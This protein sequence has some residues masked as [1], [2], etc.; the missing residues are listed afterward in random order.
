MRHLVETVHRRSETFEIFRRSRGGERRQRAAVEGAFE[1]DD[2]IALGG[3]F[4]ELIVAHQLDDAFHRFRAGIAEEDEVGKALF[5]QPRGELVAVRA[6]E[7][8]RHVPEP[9]RLLLQGGDQS[10]VAM[11]ERVDRDARGEI[12]VALAIGGGEPAALAAREAEIDPGKDGKQMRRGAVAHGGFTYDLE[13]A[14]MRALARSPRSP[15][16]KT[17]RPPFQ[18]ARRGIL[19]V[20]KWLSMLGGSGFRPVKPVASRSGGQPDCN[21]YMMEHVDCGP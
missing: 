6:L 11:A 9:G 14:A 5:A 19:G 7:Q 4:R 1:G 13:P 10:R 3:A 16:S 20:R 21:T 15:R 17:K 18:A 2:A 12:E 8:V